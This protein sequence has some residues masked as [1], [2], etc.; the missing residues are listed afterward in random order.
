[1]AFSDMNDVEQ[2]LG[3]EKPPA[4]NSNRTF[5]IIAGT[6]GGIMVLALLCIAGLALSRNLPGQQAARNAAATTAAQDT[7]SAVSASLTAAVP[8]ATATRQPTFTPTRT[9]APTN[10]PVLV[11]VPTKSPTTSGV[12]ATQNALLTQSAQQLVT[13]T[14]AASA[15]GATPTKTKTPTAKATTTGGTATALPSTGFAEEVGTP[16]LIV[17]AFVLLAVIFI[18]RKLR[19]AA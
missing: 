2:E 4:K 5:L 6:L 13:I 12:I 15:T 8:T 16:G 10:T 3:E 18:L 11:I 19:T 9:L 14:P 7:A 17:A 1:M